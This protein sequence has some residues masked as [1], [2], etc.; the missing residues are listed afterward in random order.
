MTPTPPPSPPPTCPYVAAKITDSADP[1]TSTPL[2]NADIT[3]AEVALYVSLDTNGRPIEMGI[4]QSSGYAALDRAA[5]EA[6]ARSRYGAAEEGCVPIPSH[7]IFYV[8]A[9][10]NQYQEP[11]VE[12]LRFPAPSGWLSADDGL[13]FGHGANVGAW[14]NGPAEFAV[15]AF[16]DDGKTAL[17]KYLPK[18]P[19][20]PVA[21][22][23]LTCGGKEQAVTTTFDF[24]LSKLETRSFLVRT[25][26]SGRIVYTFTY[27]VPKGDSFDP[28]MLSAL[29]AFC[30]PDRL[31]GVG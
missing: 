1:Y 14:R 13:T 28:A 12:T 18:S 15:T 24:A 20:L 9:W 23:S 5:E 8:E 27:S 11:L 3:H 7:V 29:D 25:A 30:A 19:D 26:R 2:E 4:L 17:E 22:E 6:A 16:L 21:I 10:K 31:S